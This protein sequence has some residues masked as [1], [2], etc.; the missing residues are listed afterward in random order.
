MY[1]AHTRRY[2][3]RS[4]ALGFQRCQDIGAVV[5]R[6]KFIGIGDAVA[7]EPYP[8]QRRHRHHVRSTE[9]LRL[10]ETQHRIAVLSTPRC[11]LRTTTAAGPSYATRS[12]S[13]D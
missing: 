10:A 7:G 13:A 5:P 4:V 8:G 11:S 9:P 6:G 12:P 2:T 3:V 1:R